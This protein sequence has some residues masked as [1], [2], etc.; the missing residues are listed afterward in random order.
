MT[1]CDFCGKPAEYD[2]RT[3]MGPWANM[4]ETCYKKQG[5]GLGLGKGQKLSEIGKKKDLDNYELGSDEY[6][7]A[8]G[9]LFDEDEL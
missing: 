2:A 5:V 7:E 3:K 6:L 9:E 8:M 4:C 1:T